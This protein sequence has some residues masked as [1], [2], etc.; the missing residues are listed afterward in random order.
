MGPAAKSE[1]APKVSL[2]RG[3]TMDCKGKRNGKSRTIFGKNTG[4]VLDAWKM[5]F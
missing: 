5:V 1:M 3:V 2:G 4:P